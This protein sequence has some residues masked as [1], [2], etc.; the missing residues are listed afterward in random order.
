MNKNDF[1]LLI[2][3]LKRHKIKYKIEGNKIVIGKARVDYLTLFGFIIIPVT[4][5]AS[6]IYFMI[7][8]IDLF[9]SSPIKISTL[10]VS[11]I[12]ISIFYIL[13]LLSN[14]AMNLNTKTLYNQSIRFENKHFSTNLD[15]KNI[16]VIDYT[17][18]YIEDDVYEGSL[19]ILDINDNI[20]PILG[21]DDENERYVQSDLKW[22]VNYF[23]T[24]LNMENVN[25]KHTNS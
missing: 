1:L 12:G 8:N 17:C 16:K 13:R 3:K 21:F 25:E 14:R 22:Y 2:S 19:F 6:L 20:F 9:L 15:K 11:S 7:N 4:V 5:S 18:N 24:F 23:Y 10:I